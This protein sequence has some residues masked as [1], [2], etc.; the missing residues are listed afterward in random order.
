MVIEIAQP[1]GFSQIGKRSNNEDAIFPVAGSATVHTNF[2]L[3]CDGMGG[4]SNGEIASHL[5][6]DGFVDYFENQPPASKN[7]KDIISFWDNALISIEERF[8]QYIQTNPESKGMGTTLCLFQINDN[9]ITI[10]HIGDSRV[11]QIRQNQIV[12]M[13]E[14]HSM[15]NELLKT[16]R[17]TQA[18]ALNH[19]NKNVITRA[20]QGASIPTEI[21]Y[22]FITNIEAGD[23]FFMCTDGVLEQ[24]NDR[25]L[26]DI[27]NFD[28]ASL[29][30][31]LKIVLEKC[32][33][34][35]KDNY[36][37]YLIEVKNVINNQ[38]IPNQALENE[39]IFYNKEA[40][41]AEE[42][43]R[44]IIQIVKVPQQQL[45]TKSKP[46]VLRRTKDVMMGFFYA[47]LGLV[48]FFIIYISFDFFTAK[49]KPTTTPSETKPHITVPEKNK[50]I[51]NIII[52]ENDKKVEVIKP[53]I[54]PH[55]SAK[56]EKVNLPNPKKVAKPTDTTKKKTSE[57][58]QE[59]D[60][61]LSPDII[62]V[63]KKP[64][65]RDP[66]FQ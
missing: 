10:G 59:I 34:L 65:N 41:V 29:E 57:S 49:Q 44:P 30:E 36:S 6:I 50:I 63:E 9:G 17:L 52:E 24:I 22:D 46:K 38:V 20:I 55:K 28:G 12:F 13:T 53:K 25:I 62:K 21:Q 58:V 48:L 32:Q 31:K 54:V 35:T 8:D 14:D 26:V 51:P 42:I 43:Y 27:L 15:V 3:V 45:I 5:A 18:E 33:S 2:F 23:Y 56:T 7:P 39:A 1:F 16:G 64:K 61:K 4:H 47:F 37:G 66:K 60:A 40:E 19:P 11:Y